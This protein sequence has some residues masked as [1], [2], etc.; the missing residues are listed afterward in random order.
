MQCPRLSKFLPPVRLKVWISLA[1]PVALA[2]AI[3][4]GIGGELQHDLTSV[5]RNDAASLYAGAYKEGIANFPDLGTWLELGLDPILFS[6]ALLIVT[7]SLYR[8]TL[9]G[10]ALVTGAGTAL[11]LSL[12]D[13]GA[14]LF[15]KDTEDALALSLSAD[16]LAGISIGLAAV[17]VLKWYVHLWRRFN[18]SLVSLVA[19]SSI[20]LAAAVSFSTILYLALFF[21]FQPTP[22][23]INAR[24]EAPARGFFVSYSDDRPDRFRKGEEP[25]RAFSIIPPQSSGAGAELDLIDS[26]PVLSWRSSANG[27]TFDARV[28]LLLDCGP[29]A[30]FEVAS[31]FTPAWQLRNV[32]SLTITVDR[33]QSFA[34]V[35]GGPD[36]K[37]TLDVHGGA[38]FWL[39]KANKARKLQRNVQA[40][41]SSPSRLSAAGSAPLKFALEAPLMRVTEHRFATSVLRTMKL[42]ANG[43]VETLSAGGARRYTGGRL[44]CR[45]APASA[46]DRAAALATAFDA[47]LVAEIIQRRDESRFYAV[48][49]GRLSVS[50]I[51]GW[52]KID[53]PEVGDVSGRALGEAFGITFAGKVV[54]ATIDGVELKPSEQDGF[55]AYG[56][57]RGT[58]EDSGYRIEGSAK[59]LWRN[60]HRMNPTRWERMSTELQAT[61]LGALGV[62]LFA[63]AKL[64]RHAF[65]HFKKNEELFLQL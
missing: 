1:V 3:L 25:G 2:L 30:P 52:V 9:W 28:F 24:L 62:I 42:A 22:V 35:D 51:D 41:V 15:R 46:V 12:L 50:G 54:G 6:I 43:K 40:Y 57:F 56:E 20:V 44:N 58:L 45:S 55:D 21:F 8:R 59:G 17:L 16:V 63:L 26:R 33:G 5:L 23:E 19:F 31:K 34:F 27:P 4:I 53:S 37:F 39:E 36:R 60:Q 47:T 29:L 61:L 18:E 65:P 48:D 32:S 14:L 7:A 49:S 64:S 11:A 13:V 10:A 38:M